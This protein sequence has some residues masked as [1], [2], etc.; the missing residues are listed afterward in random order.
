L[1]KWKKEETDLRKKGI[2]R[3]KDAPKAAP[4]EKSVK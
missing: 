1:E 4:K 3:K 2:Q